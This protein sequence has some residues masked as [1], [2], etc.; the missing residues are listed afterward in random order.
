MLI[1]VV[2]PITGNKPEMI[3]IVNEKATFSGANPSFGK[4]R[5]EISI[6]SLI[7]SAIFKAILIRIG[8]G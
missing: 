6:L 4:S 8:E 3:P 5:N 1:T 2:R 7:N